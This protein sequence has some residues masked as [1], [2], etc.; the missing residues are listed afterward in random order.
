MLQYSQRKPQESLRFLFCSGKEN[1]PERCANTRPALTINALELRL[2]MAP[3]NGVTPPFQD[4][5]RR[6]AMAEFCPTCGALPK[7][8]CIGRRGPRK[9]IH[10]DRYA[11]ARGET[12][13]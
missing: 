1:G 2:A 11:Q 7:F 8:P 3:D 5:R 4:S 12:P 9:A 13:A 6:R 10:A